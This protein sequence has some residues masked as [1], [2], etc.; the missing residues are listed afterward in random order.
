VG[1]IGLPV[2]R[3]VQGRIGYGTEQADVLGHDERIPAVRV[4]PDW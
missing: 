4:D 3:S 2:R 1:L